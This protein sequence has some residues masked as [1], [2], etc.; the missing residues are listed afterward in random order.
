MGQI[1]ALAR[2]WRDCFPQNANALWGPQKTKAEYMGRISKTPRSISNLPR[3]GKKWLELCL[4]W[5]KDI[6]LWLQL[7]SPRGPPPQQ[8]STPTFTIKTAPQQTIP[9]T[10]RNNA[11]KITKISRWIG[12]SISPSKPPFEGNTNLRKVVPFCGL[13][14]THN[15]IGLPQPPVIKWNLSPSL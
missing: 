15:H 2:V 1:Y 3:Q 8:P 4:P 11:G 12:T 14:R 7:R 6:I 9:A 10:S 5:A 13:C